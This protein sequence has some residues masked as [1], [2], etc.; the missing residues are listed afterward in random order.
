MRTK[1]N[2]AFLIGD[3]DAADKALA[4]LAEIRRA[5]EAEEGKL[6][7]T[8]DKM[9][10]LAKERLAAKLADKKAIEAALVTFAGSK[11]D[12]LFEKARSRQLNFGTIGFRRST[13]IKA[14]G[15]GTLAG[16][17]ERVKTLITGEPDDPFA[18]AVRVKEELNRDEMVK[19]PDERLELVGARRAKKDLFYYELKAEEIKEAAA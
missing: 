5:V 2:P 12:E 10:A 16:I 6:N 4:R 3:L 15:K 11:K 9:K 8:I 18:G 14:K 17:L 19:W 1:P 13:E 7:E